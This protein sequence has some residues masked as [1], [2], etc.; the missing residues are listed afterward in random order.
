MPQE[1]DRQCQADG[2]VRQAGPFAQQLVA[3]VVEQIAADD[4]HGENRA[5]GD[6]RHAL[7]D[8]RHRSG[9]D[10]PLAE[11]CPADLVTIEQKETPPDSFREATYRLASA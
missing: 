8:D 7:A 1:N 10:A 6:D 3:G 11:C 2:P 5:Q 4:Q 9:W